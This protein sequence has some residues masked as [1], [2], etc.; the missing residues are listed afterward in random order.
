MRE[1]TE[2]RPKPMVEVGGMPILWHIMKGYA[3][4][5]YK[6]FILCLGYKA[7]VIKDYFL[8]YQ[9]AVNDF[10]LNIGTH[11][12]Q[13]LQSGAER[14]D[15]EIS[16]VD[17]GSNTLT[18]E[19]LLRVAHLLK[20]TPFMLTYGDGVS[21]IDIAALVQHHKTMNAQHGIMGTITATHPKSKYGL[22]ATD[23]VGR[24]TKFSQYPQL[25][26]YTNAGFMVFESGILDMCQPGKMIEDTLIEATNQGKMSA[27]KHEG[28]WHSMDTVKDKEDLEKLWASGPAWKTWR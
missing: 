13:F 7:W 22:V 20:D 5:G 6:R 25:P 15:F 1:E 27:Y 26:D 2:F 28:F 21:D 18:S 4:Y 16:F 9:F 14:D 17:T 8:T 19:R 10:I 11:S 24:L 12:A 23:E 3:Q